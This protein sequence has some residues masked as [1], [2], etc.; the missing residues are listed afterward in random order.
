MCLCLFPILGGPIQN[1]TDHK[2]SK[3]KQNKVKQNKNNILQ[4]LLEKQIRKIHFDFA[5][6]LEM[7]KEI[8]PADIGKY[9]EVIRKAQ[10]EMSNM[11]VLVCGHCNN[12]FHFLEK[13]REHKSMQCSKSS[14]L[15]DNLETKPVIWSFLL[16]KT[17]QM[18]QDQTKEANAWRLYQ[19][20][21]KLDEAIKETWVV[22]GRTIQSFAKIGQ[23]SLQ[24]MP[25]KITKTVVDNSAAEPV[26]GRQLVTNRVVNKTPMSQKELD[27]SFNELKNSETSTPIGQK[28]PIVRSSPTKNVVR[29]GTTV[30]QSKPGVVAREAWRTI[31]Q[32]PNGSVQTK[33]HRIEKI[34]AKR[35]NP[36]QKEHEYLIKWENLPH[37][38]NTW[39]P[40]SH[41]EPCPVLLDTF[42]KQLARQ[43][44][45]RQA[46]AAKIAQAQA[47]A[48]T[49]S[50]QAH[51]DSKANDS[52][53]SQSEDDSTSGIKRRKLETS[54]LKVA[55]KIETN[56]LS[57]S[58]IAG[59]IKPNGIQASASNEKSAEVVITNAKDGKQ[60]GI[61]KRTGVS[62]NPTPK[63]EAQIKVIPKGGDSISGVVR[64]AAATAAAT[65]TNHVS[66]AQQRVVQKL[67]NTTVKSVQNVARPPVKAQQKT[68]PII[69]THAQAH[70]QPRQQTVSTLVQYAFYYIY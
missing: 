25:V 15:K 43:K 67:G 6:Q 54:P 2:R 10:A 70:V 14:T 55:N 35:F 19:N 60:T 8:D 37:D 11:D 64:V 1:Y 49:Q 7:G 51:D 46:Q 57:R 22:A 56:S 28:R 30:I 47:Q 52:M 50:Q 63:N 61:V 41:L 59:K 53:S 68:A 13:F 44:E 29:V 48:Q 65:T 45:Q 42:E 27:A 66:T 12:V 20:W 16:W 24:E 21:M 18:N 23:G 62:I 17:S 31:G 40:A 9:P 58:S 26:R 69:P 36:R 38:N 5:S 4:S 34:L 39:E 33:E 3:T 32:S